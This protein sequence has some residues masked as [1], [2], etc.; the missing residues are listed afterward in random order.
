MTRHAP[1][2]TYAELAVQLGFVGDDGKPNTSIHDLRRTQ[3]TNLA[4][5]GVLPSLIDLIHGRKLPGVGG[6]YNRHSYLKEKRA[7][8]LAW[9]RELMRIVEN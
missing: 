6:V 7:A 9:E 1:D 2:H 5:L 3:A 8:L 4:R